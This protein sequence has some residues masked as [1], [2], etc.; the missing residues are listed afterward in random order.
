MHGI[1]FAR[2]F[3]LALLLAP[4]AVTTPTAQWAPHPIPIATGAGQQIFVAGVHDTAGGNVVV[5]AD[6]ASGNYDIIAQRVADAGTLSWGAGVAVCNLALTQTNPQV[7][8]DGGSGTIALWQ[9]AR[10]G[11]DDVYAQRLDSG[12]AA[13][14]AANGKAI[15]TDAANQQNPAMLSDGAGGAFAA[16]TDFR[17]DP[18]GDVYAIRIDANGD[19]V[20]GWPVDGAAVC[21]AVDSQDSVKLVSDGT[22]GVIVVWRDR[23]AGDDDV[24][25]QRLS[26]GGVAAWAVDGAAVVAAAGDQAPIYTAWD[27]VT[28]CCTDG[29]AGAIVGWS[30]L[31]A[32]D[33]VLWASRIDSAGVV[34]WT[35]NVCSQPGSKN[36]FYLVS[37]GVGGAVMAW[38]D[39]RNGVDDD[40][41]GQRLDAGGVAAWTVDGRLIGGGAGN[42]SGGLIGLDGGRFF[43]TWTDDV[44]LRMMGQKIDLAGVD[45]WAAGGVDVFPNVQWGAA[46]Y[47]DGNGG[48]Y[49]F[50]CYDA[51][52][53]NQD[54]FGQ[55]WTDPNPA[56]G[57]GGASTGRSHRRHLCGIVPMAS[58]RIGGLLAASAAFVALLMLL[59]RG[60]ATP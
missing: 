7:V 40:F 33:P 56:A 23:R 20:A 39:G 47:G 14:W 51:G 1:G 54:L 49:L 41:Y 30:D 25:A 60:R 38:A 28:Y 59:R 9:D 24:Y 15:C 52:G 13:L 11:N 12:G 21:G 16:W 18:S 17:I 34:Q 53:G 19:P 2:A 46:A 29:A 22:G 10:A 58:E 50:F 31:T 37:D 35:S 43:Y 8:R 55:W 6:N 3:A 44:L 26:G 57:G 4:M 27:V 48:V 45:Q 42:Q 5:W 36:A 32:P